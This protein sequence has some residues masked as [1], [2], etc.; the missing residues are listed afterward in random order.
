MS[1]CC[2]NSV[3]LDLSCCACGKVTLAS[4]RR[5]IAPLIKKAYHLYFGCKL[6][7]QTR[8]GRRT[9]CANRLQYVLETGLAVREWRCRLPFQWC[10][11]NPQTT[12]VTAT[13]AWHLL[14]Q[15]VWIERRSRELTIQIYPLPSDLCLMV[16]VGEQR[17][18]T[19]LCQKNM[20]YLKDF[21]ARTQKCKAS[22]TGWVIEEFVATSSYHIRPHEEF[23]EGY[24]S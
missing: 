16:W 7:D 12:T 6:G 24:G 5:F 11:G 9:L 22:F 23:D 10:G 19:S 18:A 8:S 4:Q 1:R 17:Q 2:V 3:D 20:A 14:W 15:V 21:G 13:F